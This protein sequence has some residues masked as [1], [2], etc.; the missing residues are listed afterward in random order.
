MSHT[1]ITRKIAVAAAVAIVLAVVSIPFLKPIA[2]HDFPPEQTEAAFTSN[3]PQSIYAADPTDS[4]NRI[5]HLLFTRTVNADMSSD[6]PEAGPFT[7]GEA[8][9][10]SGLR[11]STR[12]FE[13]VEIGDRAIEPLYPSFLSSAG[14]LGVLTE[15]RFSELRESLT[16][17]ISDQNNRPPIARALMQCDVWAAYDIIFRS[18]NFRTGDDR[19]IGEHKEVLL[20]LLAQFIRKLALSSAEIRWLPP[21]YS[22]AEKVKNLPAL[23]STE[24]GWLEI[25]LLPDRVHDFNS[26]Y[27]RA[28]RVF[29]KPRRVPENKTKFVENLKDN[30]HSEEL[31]AVA[32]AVQNLLVDTSGRAV[33][34]PIISDV[35]IRFFSNGNVPVVSEAKEY[36]LSRRLLLT[37]P[38]SGGLLEFDDN[39]PAYLVAA[40]ND[41]DFATPLFATHTPV[42][43][44]LHARCAQCHGTPL[45]HLMTLSIIPIPPIPPVTILNA[46]NSDQAIYVASRKEQ[47]DDYKSLLSRFREGGKASFIIMPR[48]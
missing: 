13:R 37:H 26:S 31:E 12:R 7:G 4:W 8:M 22:A 14:A 36:E 2:R 20:S 11:I 44:T 46:I 21:T 42:V 15:P 43:A 39:A 25:R 47:R 24:S 28:A 35:Q 10:V 30:Q 18:G 32:L 27:R 19:Q 23:F 3:N 40:G 34:S 33:P 5:F 41:Y 48:P 1:F 29:V 9:A 6:F 38:V 45:K 16:T 17:A